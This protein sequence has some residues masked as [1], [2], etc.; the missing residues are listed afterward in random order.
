VA[1]EVIDLMRRAVSEH[2]QVQIEYYSFG[3][4]SATSRVIDPYSLFAASGQWYVS[5]FCHAVDDE[6][7]FRLDRVRVA[8]PLQTTFA[9][10]AVAPDL[11]VYQPQSDDPRVALDLA[12]GARWVIEQYPV[13]AVEAR[14]EGGWRVRLVASERAWLERLLLRLGRDA[15]VVEGPVDAAREAAGRLL[16]RYR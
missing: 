10:P 12:P 13:E 6:R 7:L 16:E 3:R 11:T 15:R 2:R 8:T 14:P 4:D 9:A 1:T 5:A